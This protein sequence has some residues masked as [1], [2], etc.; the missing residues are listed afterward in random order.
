MSENESGTLDIISR[1]TSALISSIG[2]EGLFQEVVDN[3]RKISGAKYVS[4]SVYD[5]ERGTVRP[6][7]FSGIDPTVLTKFV[8]MLGVKDVFQRELPVG[9]CASFKRFLR[10]RKKRPIILKDFHEYTFGQ[11]S[12]RTCQLIEKI[13]GIKQIVAIPL[14][15]GK[16]LEGFLGY[17]YPTRERRDFTP[18]LVFADFAI[19]AIDKT[20]MFNQL[21]QARDDLMAIFETAGTAMA[22]VEEDMTISMVNR[23]AEDLF[24]YS[25][26]EIEG[27]SWTEFVPEE[28][29]EKLKEYHLLRRRDP[30]A[31]P[32][33]YELR[34]LDRFGSAKVVLLNISL[35]PGT[36]RS[37]VSIMDI[38]ERK[39]VE[40]ERR[41]R[42]LVEMWSETLTGE[43]IRA[44]GVRALPEEL[45]LPPVLEQMANLST[46]PHPSAL[47]S[48][49][50]RGIQKRLQERGVGAS[51]EGVRKALALSVLR[52]LRGVFVVAEQF[53]RKIPVEY[54]E[55]ERELSKSMKG[56][57]AVGQQQ[58]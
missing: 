27:K 19:Q 39:Q 9:E 49:L 36:K 29:L 40:E 13:A 18:L 3:A 54:R 48:A 16:K 34:L 17:L 20:K 31:V 46:V 25:K 33:S 10:K 15:R 7:A 38:T 30:S 8:R 28:D 22:I 56:R 6:V 52:F 50:I 35:I 11:F 24:G 32:G 44:F 57:R 12:R 47:F 21:R 53:G 23:R 1:T 42:G 58:D 4:L 41:W 14:L 45:G 2:S 37:V 51:E 26:E 55:F 43:I 5:E